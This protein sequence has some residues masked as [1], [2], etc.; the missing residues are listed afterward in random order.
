MRAVIEADSAAKARSVVKVNRALFTLHFI[1][2][3]DHQSNAETQR[4][5]DAKPGIAPAELVEQAA[6]GYGDT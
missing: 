5:V 3:L 6:K 2:E 1:G 4:L